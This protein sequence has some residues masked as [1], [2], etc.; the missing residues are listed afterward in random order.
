VKS[1]SSSTAP[2]GIFDSGVGGISI[3]KEIQKQLPNENLIYIADSANAPYGD[4]P[5]EFIQK[6]SLQLAEFLLSHRIK[7]LVIACNTATTEAISYLR[8]HLEIPVVGVEPAIKPAAEQSKNKVIG[9]LATHRTIQ[10]GRLQELIAL[11]A[12]NVQVITQ[13]CPGLVEAVEQRDTPD[14]LASLIREYTKKMVTH[15]ADT[16]ILGC[17]HYPFL[18][19]KIRDVLGEE[20]TILDTGK[21]VAS[22]LQRILEKNHIS[23]S[24]QKRNKS[25][26]QITFYSSL[27]DELHHRTINKLW[28]SVAVVTPLPSLVDT[29]KQ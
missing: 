6:R 23:N 12:N 11:Y 19:S 29:E 20:I 18:L 15:E 27:N 17:T 21:P 25:E 8:E 7:A 5:V 9:I 1:S 4:K 24:L 16:I 26:G 13:S 3:L 10:S 14:N 22:Q 28:D 2:I